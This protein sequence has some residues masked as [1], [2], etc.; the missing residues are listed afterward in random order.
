MNTASAA[1]KSRRSIRR[2][3]GSSIHHDSLIV[4]KLLARAA[5]SGPP[6]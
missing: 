6:V 2:I 5:I 4:G 3:R 1:A